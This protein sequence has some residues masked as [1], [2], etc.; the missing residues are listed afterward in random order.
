[1]TPAKFEQT[2]L[3]AIASDLPCGGRAEFIEYTLYVTGIVPRE[4]RRIL[5]RIRD[6]G[7]RVRMSQM[8]SYHADYTFAYDFVA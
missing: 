2:I 5:S 3:K 8:G 4:G 7:H 6:L 1:M